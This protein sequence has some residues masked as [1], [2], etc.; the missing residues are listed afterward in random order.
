MI[1]N[2]LPGERIALI[3]TNEHG[4]R[5]DCIGIVVERGDEPKVRIDHPAFVNPP[6]LDLV[7]ELIETTESGALRYLGEMRGSVLIPS[8]L[9]KP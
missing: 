6:Q 3:A 7:G 4:R 9:W 8:F 1:R 5:L 2:F